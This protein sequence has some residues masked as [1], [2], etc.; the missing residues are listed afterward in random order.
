M[1]SMADVPSPGAP[2]APLGRRIADALA[3]AEKVLAVGLLVLVLVI[4]FVQVIA[5]FIFDAPFFWTEELAR[6]SYVWLSFIAAVFVMGD[7]SHITVEILDARMRPRT[8]QAIGLFAMVA[9]IVSCGALAVG[10][11]ELVTEQAGASPALGIPTSVFYGV[12][13]ACFIGMGLYAAAHAVRIVLDPSLSSPHPD[14]LAEES[15]L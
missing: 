10:S 15:A 2:R 1:N 6:Y 11:L 13:Y 5:R 8:R 4:T 7:R 9:V 3:A 12:V 14:R